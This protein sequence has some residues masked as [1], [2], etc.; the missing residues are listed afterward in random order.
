M[1]FQNVLNALG[2]HVNLETLY[3]SFSF[4]EVLMYLASGS[5]NRS[6]KLIRST[7]VCFR[8]THV[9][10]FVTHCQGKWKVFVAWASLGD[11]LRYWPTDQS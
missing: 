11:T 5:P 1:L 7:S 4:I 6:I 3:L 2:R 9:S 8:I 10:L